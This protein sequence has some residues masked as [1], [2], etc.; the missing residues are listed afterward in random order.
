VS[1]AN[2]KLKRPVVPQHNIVYYYEAGIRPVLEYASPVWHI[3]LT[4][5]HALTLESAQQW[6][7]HII[8]GDG[9]TDNC[10][11]L[12]LETLAERHLTQSREQ[13]QQVM[14]NSYYCLHTLL[15]PKRDNF[16][17]SRLRNAE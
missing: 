1:Q 10:A 16:I 3:S 2:K 14:H 4:A 8:A 13:F 6:A 11:L 9:N 5:D 17:T 12:R 7:C 15:P